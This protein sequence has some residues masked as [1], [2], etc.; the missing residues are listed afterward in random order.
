MTLPKAN[1]RAAQVFL[2]L[3]EV[4][5]SRMI[6]VVMIMLIVMIMIVVILEDMTRRILGGCFLAFTNAARPWERRE[7]IG[8]EG[9]CLKERE[10]TL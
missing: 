4:E 7:L 6:M 9:P 10:R 3:G 1:G 5:E 2:D 8:I